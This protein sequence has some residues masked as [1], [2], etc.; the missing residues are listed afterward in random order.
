MIGSGFVWNGRRF[1]LEGFVEIF[2]QNHLGL[3]CLLMKNIVGQR[4][5]FV[6]QGNVLLG[7]HANRHSRIAHGLGGARGLNLID[8]IVK[9]HG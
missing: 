7:I 6:K 3:L 2:C 8:H 1:R 4:L 5:V 9:L